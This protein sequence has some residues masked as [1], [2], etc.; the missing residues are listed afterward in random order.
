MTEE[1]EE[2]SL[3][4]QFEE[5][6]AGGKNREIREFLDHQNI[7]DVVDLVYEFPEQESQIVAN[8]STHRA[9]NVFKLLEASNQKDIIRALPPSVTAAL[10]NAMPADDRTDF[11]EELRGD[12]VRELIKLL[13]P[14]ERRITLTLLGY[15]ENSIGR[16]MNPDYVYV[17]A[18]NTIEEVFETIKNM[19]KIARPSM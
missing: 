16:L 18:H 6:L 1:V 5:L 17:Y 11:F 9:V 3:K 15:P 7:A 2:I 10:L 4:E 13:D 14:D 19:V 8:M 12:A